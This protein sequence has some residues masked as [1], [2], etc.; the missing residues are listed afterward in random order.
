MIDFSPDD[1]QIFRS[2]L[3]IPLSE[4]KRIHISHCFLCQDFQKPYYSKLF[5]SVDVGVTGN[6]FLRACNV[7][8]SPE[9]EDIARAI[10]S[11]SR[12]DGDYN[13][14]RKFHQLV[15]DDA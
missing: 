8:D 13:D 9:A 15:N 3:F 6:S 10:A 7:R 2:Q 11:Q 12:Y 5:A 4:N 14:L 1:Y